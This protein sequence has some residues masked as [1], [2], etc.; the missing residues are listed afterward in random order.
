MRT[1]WWTHTAPTGYHAHPQ[2]A[3]SIQK[4][5]LR[6]NSYE[7][8]GVGTRRAGPC[9]QRPEWQCLPVGPRH[10]QDHGHP[11]Q[12]KK[13]R[14]IFGGVQP[15]RNHPGR[16]RRQRLLLPMEN[17]DWQR[18]QRREPAQLVSGFR[19]GLLLLALVFLSGTLDHVDEVGDEVPSKNLPTGL[20]T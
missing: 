4:T 16:W 2:T 17:P 15:G 10:R 13:P 7:R 1:H 20:K 8:S 5:Q 3:A 6:L 9:Y 19:M 11:H 14:S 12:S 18:H